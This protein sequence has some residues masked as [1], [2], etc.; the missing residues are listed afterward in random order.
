VQECARD[1][2]TD[3]DAFVKAI[4]IRPEHFDQARARVEGW[5]KTHPVEHA[6]SA[7]AFPAP[8]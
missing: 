4:A 1:L 7:R 5:A 8:L 6:F 2:L 3:A